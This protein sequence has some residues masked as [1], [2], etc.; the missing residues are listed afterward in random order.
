[1]QETIKSTVGPERQPQPRESHGPE[2]ED[3]GRTHSDH[4]HFHNHRFSFRST[5]LKGMQVNQRVDIEYVPDGTHTTISH[6]GPRLPSGAR[7]SYP[8]GM[9]NVHLRGVE[10]IFPGQSYY[11]P[12][13]EF[14]HTPNSGCV[15]TLMEKL[16]EGVIHASSV[17]E[18]GHL[19][20]DSF[21]RFQF[22][23]AQ[24]WR[25]VAEAFEA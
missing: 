12:E 15:I 22:T 16:T 1:M 20:D 14:H 5:V 21:D 8:V 23:P 6:D 13:L 2:D 17:I 9:A 25:F 18:R 24:L 4:G 10:F 11:T 3:P 19:F 7:K